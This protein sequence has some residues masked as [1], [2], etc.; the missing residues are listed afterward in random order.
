MTIH[1]E[2]NGGPKLI[3]FCYFPPAFAFPPTILKF[4][5]ISVL[6]RFKEEKYGYTIKKLY[7]RKGEIQLPKS[8]QISTFV[9]L[10]G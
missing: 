7:Q 9:L 2:Q 8:R 4:W 3:L 5:N 6:M 1:L 10:L